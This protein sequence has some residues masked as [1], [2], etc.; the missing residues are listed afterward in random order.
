MYATFFIKPASSMKR[1]RRLSCCSA[2]SAATEATALTEQSDVSEIDVTVRFSPN[3]NVRFSLSLNDYTPE[4]IKATW[5]EDE[6][7]TKIRKDCCKQIKK[8]QNG[9]VLKDKKYSSRGLES[10]IRSAAITKT[11]NRRTASNAVLDEQEE[12]R[13]T[14]VVDEK[15]IAR[16]YQ[17]TSISCQLSASTVGLRDQRIAE[18]YMD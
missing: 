3:A 11:L 2:T 18:H 13:Q 6:E 17:K 4:E 15:A 10:H 1:P 16:R 7:Y 14:G 5:Y 8:M 9:E 12:Q